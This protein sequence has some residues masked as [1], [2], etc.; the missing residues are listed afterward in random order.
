M[1]LQQALTLTGVQQNNAKALTLA[2]LLTDEEC[3]TRQLS[4]ETLGVMR[5][6]TPKV[7][8]SPKLSKVLLGLGLPQKVVSLLL[9]A[10]NAAALPRVS[11][12]SEDLLEQGDSVHYESCQSTG[13]PLS[14][15]S[16]EIQFL[17]ESL[18]LF[19]IGQRK[20]LDGQGFTA[21]AKIRLMTLDPEGQEPAGFYLERPY[22]QYSSLLMHLEVL[23]EWVSEWC[24]EK[25]LTPLPILIAPV[26]QRDNGGSNDFQTLYGGSY[27]KS[28]YCPSCAG[29][30]M[31]TMVWGASAR[32]DF[33]KEVARPEPIPS[34]EDADAYKAFLMRAVKKAY[35]E[36]PFFVGVYTCALNEHVWNPQIL[37]FQHPPLPKRW[38]G[39]ITKAHRKGLKTLI[40]H[41]G[42]PKAP[43]Y[44][45]DADTYFMYKESHDTAWLLFPDDGSMH[46]DD[47]EAWVKVIDNDNVVHSDCPERGFYEALNISKAHALLRAKSLLGLQPTVTKITANWHEGQYVFSFGEDNTLRVRYKN[48]R[49]NILKVGISYLEVL[50]D[51]PEIGVWKAVELPTLDENVEDEVE[52]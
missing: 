36:R 31:D 33:F 17:G 32:Y 4:K 43:V 38:R 45:G 44:F 10:P 3:Q 20:S 8:S 42:Y 26:W 39:T 2:A 51:I 28:L 40:K 12:I 35:M 47:G 37:G 23:R 27:A 14:R 11:S 21:R 24:K 1:K 22:G 5:R 19:V 13:N 25:G 34:R 41:L 46:V 49:R 7:G 6:L 9:A 29:G 52:F 16:Q 15:V 50:R 18:W 48:K 30:Y